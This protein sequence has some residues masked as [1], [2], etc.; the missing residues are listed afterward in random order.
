MGTA[1]NNQFRKAPVGFKGGKS[2]SSEENFLP[3]ASGKRFCSWRKNLRKFTLWRPWQKGPDR[4]GRVLEPYMSQFA[5]RHPTA[6][7][8]LFAVLQGGAMLGLNVLLRALVS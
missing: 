7:I 4:R 6:V 3:Q 8:W 5:E 1:D 2:A